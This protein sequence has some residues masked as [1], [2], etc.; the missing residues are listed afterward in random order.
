MTD[1]ET[2]AGMLEE[3]RKRGVRCYLD[4]FGTGYSSMS[5]LYRLPIDALK[6]DRSF[7]LGLK[8]E[9]EGREIVRMIA[10][11]GQSLGKKVIAE[12]IES[13]AQLNALLELRCGFGQGY[14][15]SRP[16]PKEEA[17]RLLGKGGRWGA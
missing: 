14:H 1:R 11:L 9:G 6:I 13:T 7:V 10:S 5:Y 15:F 12:G 3:L 16:L 8:P 4:D 2:A 17:G